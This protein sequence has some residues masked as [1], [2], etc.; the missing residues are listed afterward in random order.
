MDDDVSSAHKQVKYNPEVAAA[1]CTIVQKVLII[2]CG[3]QFGGNASSYCF[4]ATAKVR[5]LLAEFLA[6]HDPD[7][8]QKHSDYISKIK[9]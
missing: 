3:Q 8:N 4:E 6:K 2:A 9:L 7:I 5:S 1:F